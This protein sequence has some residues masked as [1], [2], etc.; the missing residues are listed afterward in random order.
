MEGLFYCNDTL[1]NK[2]GN[3]LLSQD[4][5]DIQKDENDVLWIATQANGVVLFK[6]GIVKHIT[7]KNGLAGDNCQK[8]FLDEN[9]AWIATTR[10]ISKINRWDFSFKNITTSDGL[11]LS[12]I[13]I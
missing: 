13:H 7:T 12:L 8:I 11:P 5:R 6:D 9:F 3:E 4:I 10:G 1:C 2:V